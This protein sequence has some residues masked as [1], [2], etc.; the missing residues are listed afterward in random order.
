M[1]MRRYSH[2]VQTVH[3]NR[4]LWINALGFMRRHW[5]AHVLGVRA[6]VRKCGL[7]ALDSWP[8]MRDGCL[9]HTCGMRT[10]MVA[11]EAKKCATKAGVSHRFYFLLADTRRASETDVVDC[12]AEAIRAK[13]ANWRHF[14]NTVNRISYDTFLIPE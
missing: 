11:R 14:K 3:L 12:V 4:K 9:K 10:H 8:W 7:M 6:R 1:H 5:A 13:I 2:V